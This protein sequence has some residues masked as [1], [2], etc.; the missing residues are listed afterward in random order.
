MA[1]PDGCPEERQGQ[2]IIAQM[3]PFGL[4]MGNI[5]D[6]EARELSELAEDVEIDGVREIG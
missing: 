5:T 4:V 1:D 2:R 6:A 3:G